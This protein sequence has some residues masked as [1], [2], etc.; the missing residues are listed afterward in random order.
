MQPEKKPSRRVQYTCDAL[1]TALIELL[2]QKP[3]KN[4]TVKDVCARADINRSTF[5]LHYQDVYDLMETI[6]TD[7][8]CEMNAAAAFAVGSDPL[9]HMT[10]MLHAIRKNRL[11]CLVILSEH[12]SPQFIKRINQMSRENFI[13]HWHQHFPDTP[14]RRL[15]LVYS[16]ASSGSMAVIEQWLLGDCK[17]SPEEIAELLNIFATSCLRCHTAASQ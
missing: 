14:L 11:I 12:G 6:E 3:I 10:S 7:L 2:L 4:I 9:S 5:Y 13:G 15:E 8:I 16:F 1:R 17:E